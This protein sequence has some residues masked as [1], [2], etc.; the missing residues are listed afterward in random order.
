ME[1]IEFK[2][3]SSAEQIIF[4]PNF[5]SNKSSRRDIERSINN[6][7]VTCEKEYIFQK[8]S[9]NIAKE[10]GEKDHSKTYNQNE[11]TKWRRKRSLYSRIE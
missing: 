3:E 2:S 10:R 9:D 6:G 4:M 5:K 11:T 1:L 7:V 8:E